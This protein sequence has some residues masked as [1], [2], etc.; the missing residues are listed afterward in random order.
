MNPTPANLGK[1]VPEDHWIPA[2][3]RARHATRDMRLLR[4]NAILFAL[5][6]IAWLY[7]LFKSA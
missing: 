5:N 7:Q 4:W 3:H 2:D 6:G 1:P